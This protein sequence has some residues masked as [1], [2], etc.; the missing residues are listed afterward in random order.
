MEELP[1][2]LNLH[3]HYKPQRS[4]V[5]SIRWQ[6][7]CAIGATQDV[8]CRLGGDVTDSVAGGERGI[9]A[10]GG[11][12]HGAL[13][14]TADVREEGRRIGGLFGFESPLLL[15]AVDLTQVMGAASSEGQQQ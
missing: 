15:G 13:Q 10:T 8:A 7:V 9:S 3:W 5:G 14:V 1:S 12:E 6:N 4:L 11:T 2:S